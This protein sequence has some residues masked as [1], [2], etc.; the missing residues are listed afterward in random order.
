MRCLNKRAS[1]I[2]LSQDRTIFKPFA[3]AR[4]TRQ[5][6]HNKPKCVQRI[7]HAHRENVFVKFDTVFT[8]E[9]AKVGRNYTRVGENK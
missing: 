4:A 8:S 3:D 9:R 5:R 1:K 2:T 7:G 6:M